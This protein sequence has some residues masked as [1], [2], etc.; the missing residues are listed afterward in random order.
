MGVSKNFKKSGKVEEVCS[1]LSG[2]SLQ[3]IFF[4]FLLFCCLFREKRAFIQVVLVFILFKWEA[5]W[6]RI[7]S[8]YF[9][10]GNFSAFVV[11]VLKDHNMWPHKHREK[12]VFR[13]N[14]TDKWGRGG[15]I[16]K[17]VRTFFGGG[18]LFRTT[19]LY[20]RGCTLL[21]LIYPYTTPMWHADE[22]WYTYL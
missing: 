1:L 16:D 13:K 3:I 9:C 14:R 8:S 21:D 18:S 12:G 10:L 6:Q 2:P 22:Q 11:Q 20:W 15:K 4:V 19:W 7:F 5:F 17:I